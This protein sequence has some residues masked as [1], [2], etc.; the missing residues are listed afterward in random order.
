MRKI[1]YILATILSAFLV[2]LSIV[3]GGKVLATSYEYGTDVVST[4]TNSGDTRTWD[5]TTNLP[6]SNTKPATGDDIH[7][8]IIDKGISK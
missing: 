4:T 1:K 3:V 2:M 6:A 8:I 5:F 7:D